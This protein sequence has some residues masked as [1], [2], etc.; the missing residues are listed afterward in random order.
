MVN[1]TDMTRIVGILRR[2]DFESLVGM[3]ED[4]KVEAK[5]SPYQL[6]VDRQKQ[7]LAK[8]VSALGNAGGGVILIGFETTKDSLNAVERI[9]A[10]RPF[11]RAMVDTQQYRDVLQTWVSPPIHSVQI[12]WYPSASDAKVG[13]AVVEVPPDAANEKPYIVRRVVEQDGRVRGTLVGYYERVQDRIPETSSERLR[14]W[15]RDGMRFES[16]SQRLS[17][18]EEL[19][20]N[21]ERSPEDSSPSGLTDD[22]VEKRVKEATAAVERESAPVIILTATSENPTKFPN[23]FV[24]EK[25]QQSHSWM[26]CRYSAKTALASAFIYRDLQRS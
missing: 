26:T 5:G 11:P 17:T 19:V 7:E 10:T 18:I 9:A 21:L 4:E 25:N 23:L 14:G 6:S 15:L 8:D 24:Q 13:V 3:I 12:D 2:G 1:T 20:A 16:L 22:L